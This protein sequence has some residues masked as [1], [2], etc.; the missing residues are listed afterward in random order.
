MTRI[1]VIPFPAFHPYQAAIALR[2]VVSLNLLQ[3]GSV[4]CEPGIIETERNRR[5]PRNPFNVLFHA[6]N[7]ASVAPMSSTIANVC[8]CPMIRHPV[9]RSCPVAGQYPGCRPRHC[10]CL[11]SGMSAKLLG[12]L[13]TVCCVC[14]PGNSVFEALPQLAG[15]GL[16]VS[17]GLCTQHLRLLYP[18][19]YLKMK[20]PATPESVAGNTKEPSV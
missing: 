12:G 4:S 2:Q 10:K 7:I 1:V 5:F 17:H 19:E 18:Q 6:V 3:H 8:S 13:V 14:Y 15:L 20:N 11:Y 9:R 16:Q